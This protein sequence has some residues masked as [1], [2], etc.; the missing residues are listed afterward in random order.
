MSGGETTIDG[1]S[2]DD[3]LSSLALG[4][5]AAFD[6]SEEMSLRTSWLNS[7]TDGERGVN[8]N[9]VRVQL[10]YT[11]NQASR[12][13]AR[14]SDEA[15]RSRQMNLEE[16]VAKLE[17][18]HGIGPEADLADSQPTRH[19]KTDGDEDGIP[20]LFDSCPNTPVGVSVRL[21]GCLFKSIL[22]DIEFEPGSITLTEASRIALDQTTDSLVADLMRYDTGRLE[23]RGYTDSS[24]DPDTNVDLS[25][26][27]A[28]VVFDYLLEQ[29]PALE[30]FLNRIYA[31]GYGSEHPI[32][33][34]DTKEG[35]A[36]N[37]RVELVMVEK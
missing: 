1:I 2:Q 33:S 19:S 8:T 17:A 12:E 5:T 32:A 9:M 25:H 23:V 27:R 10:F 36:Q 14:K 29:E 34:N 4:L 26:K 37:R 28:N 22:E 3:A 30:R 21:D 18:V 15:A 35:R 11:W 20:D 7:L 16:R 31:V 6:V 24:G 13:L